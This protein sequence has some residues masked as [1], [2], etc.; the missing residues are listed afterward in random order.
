MHLPRASLHL[1]WL[2]GLLFAAA[3]AI[4]G[5][6]RPGYLHA[7]HAVGLLGTG[8]RG[9]WFNAIGYAGAGLALA[10][11][12]LGLESTLSAAGLGRS[13]RLA[14]GML[15]LAGLAFAAQSLLPLDPQDYD[16]VASRRHAVA[17]AFA[18]L[19]WLPG[20]TL[21][22]VALRARRPAMAATALLGSLCLAALLLFPATR[23]WPGWEHRPGAAQRLVLGVFFLVPA[24]LALQ[25][26]RRAD[27][28]P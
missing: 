19:A 10:G 7:A 9:A 24:L 16:G 3:V 5:A 25:A 12:A 4:G 23:W 26:R 14:T 13:M 6:E 11:F 8:A 21:L 17:H 18:L 22:A 27:G 1:G 20:T 28:R 15:V 2:A